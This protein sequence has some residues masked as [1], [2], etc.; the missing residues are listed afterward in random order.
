MV[1]CQPRHVIVLLDSDKK[2]GYAAD[3]LDVTVLGLS[4]ICILVFYQNFS[5]RRIIRML[6]VLLIAGAVWT[7]ARVVMLRVRWDKCPWAD[8]VSSVL[9]L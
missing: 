3:L 2:A 7:V 1:L 5:L 8:S 6:Q 9:V 4:K